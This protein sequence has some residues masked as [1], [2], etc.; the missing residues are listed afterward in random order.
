MYS[1]PNYLK[2]PYGDAGFPLFDSYDSHEYKRPDTVS[3]Y[4][5]HINL[6]NASYKANFKAINQ[7]IDELGFTAT[8]VGFKQAN[9]FADNPILPDDTR[10]NEFWK[11]MQNNDFTRARKI[12]K[13]LDNDERKKLLE[14]QHFAADSK[15][16]IERGLMLSNIFLNSRARYIGK[17][18]YTIYLNSKYNEAQVCKFVAKCEEKIRKIPGLVPGHVNATD[19]PLSHFISF[20]QERLD[21]VDNYNFSQSEKDLA[22]LKEAQEKS[23]LYD[24]LKTEMKKLPTYEYKAPAEKEEKMLT[25]PARVLQFNFVE[26]ELLKSEMQEHKLS[27]HQHSNLTKNEAIKKYDIQHLKVVDASLSE[28][29]KYL[30]NPDDNARTTLYKNLKSLIDDARKIHHPSFMNRLFGEKNVTKTLLKT[31]RNTMEKMFPELKAVAA[32]KL[33][34]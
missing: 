1:M 11:A 18:Q 10:E 8:I 22:K 7:I 30:K 13:I 4:K 6:S 31:T 19:S 2:V 5:L 26:L 33:A 14:K 20:R 25:V 16:A 29:E 21:D 9:Y 3:R 28:F 17:A 23:Q 12:T 27:L 24:A 34:S 32:K 15:A